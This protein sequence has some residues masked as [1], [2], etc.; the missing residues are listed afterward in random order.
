MDHDKVITFERE[1][2]VVLVNMTTIGDDTRILSSDVTM[3]EF[4]AEQLA[5]EGWLGGSVGIE[6][7]SYRPNPAVSEMLFHALEAKGCNVKDCSHILR[8]VR[9][10]KSPLELSYIRT[11]AAIGDAGMRAAVDTVGA[12]V[13]ELEVYAE[14]VSAMIKAGGEA[15]A[16]TVSCASGLRTLCTDAQTTRRKIMLGD[17]GQ[18]GYLWLLSSLSHQLRTHFLG[19]RATSGS[20]RTD[21][22]SLPARLR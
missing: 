21:G 4:V 5:G 3:A 13:T 11:A 16:K 2:N 15:P 22:R 18:C 7:F 10:T 17:Y 14:I 9:G 6:R 19:G 12:G 20:R 8:E 1:V